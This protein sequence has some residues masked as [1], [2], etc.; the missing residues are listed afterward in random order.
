[1]LVSKTIDET[2]DLQVQVQF[3]SGIP[4]AGGGGDHWLTFG[5]TTPTPTPTPATTTTT[6]CTCKLR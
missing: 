6:T 2:G 4:Y 3:S 1:M 5:A